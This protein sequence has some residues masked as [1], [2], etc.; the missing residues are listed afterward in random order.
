M[1]HPSKFH[2]SPSLSDI[3]LTHNCGT[4]PPIRCINQNLKQEGHWSLCLTPDQPDRK[5][6][7]ETMPEGD[8]FQTEWDS[9][10]QNSE[11]GIENHI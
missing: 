5:P 7:L 2:A 4:A 6:E 8:H 1:S 9:K 11:I 10:V 3:L